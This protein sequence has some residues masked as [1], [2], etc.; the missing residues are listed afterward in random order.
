MFNCWDTPERPLFSSQLLVTLTNSKEHVNQRNTLQLIINNL[1][2]FSSSE[3]GV[4]VCLQVGTGVFES[5]ADINNVV[6]QHFL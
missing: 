5:V 2:I 3:G 1:C 6:S 4:Q